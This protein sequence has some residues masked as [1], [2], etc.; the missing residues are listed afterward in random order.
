MKF[1][2][3]FEFLNIYSETFVPGGG[4]SADSPAT[5]QWLTELVPE[6]NYESANDICL[7]IENGL[8]VIM[9]SQ[10]KPDKKYID[11]FK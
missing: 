11:V 6:L 9:I 1:M 10:D 5:K 2:P 8:C 7:K 4:S 3:I